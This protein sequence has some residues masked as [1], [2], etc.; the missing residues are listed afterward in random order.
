V[1]RL[2]ICFAILTIAPGFS[3]AQVA[4][5]QD[6]SASCRR[7]AQAFYDW[8][9]PFT[10]RQSNGSASDI[11]LRRKADIFEPELLRALKLDSEAQA[12][13]K[14]DLVGIDFD[15]F[16]GSQ[17]PAAR[18]EVR[19]VKW[20]GNK[21]SAEVWGAPPPGIASQPGKPDAVAE[22]KQHDGR[23]QFSNFRYPELNTDLSSVLAQLR[24]ERQKRK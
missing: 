20:Q 2:G 1:I 10:Q 13:A 18:Y 6:E 19:S 17:D 5:T 24:A 14:G 4:S 15:P 3:N 16:V 23:W 11:A 9:V 21:C 8:Y 22:V 12:R 7:F